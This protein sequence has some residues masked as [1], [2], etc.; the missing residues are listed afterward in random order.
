MSPIP[1]VK[2]K[3]S[4]FKDLK[5]LIAAELVRNPDVAKNLPGRVRTLCDQSMGLT[6]ITFDN[7][8]RA[9]NIMAGHGW[10]PKAMAVETLQNFR[11]CFVIME[12]KE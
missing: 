6:G 11:R 3:V 10:T 7:I 5:M 1:E 8:E 12:K 2:L 4:E 9:M